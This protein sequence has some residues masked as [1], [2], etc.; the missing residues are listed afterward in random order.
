MLTFPFQFDP[1]SCMPSS[2]SFPHCLDTFVKICKHK[3]YSYFRRNAFFCPLCS[4]ISLNS[5]MVFTTLFNE[6]VIQNRKSLQSSFSNTI[7][8]AQHQQEE[9]AVWIFNLSITTHFSHIY[10]FFFLVKTIAPGMLIKQQTSMIYLA[11]VSLEKFVL[12]I[13]FSTQKLNESPGL[14]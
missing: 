7:S 3:A 4:R 13:V 1:Y 14:S 11:S 6:S 5:S 12:H 9:K 2:Q 10:S 8:V